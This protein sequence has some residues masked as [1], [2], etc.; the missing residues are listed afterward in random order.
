MHQNNRSSRALYGQD[1]HKQRSSNRSRSHALS[2]DRNRALQLDQRPSFT[3]KRHRH[4][5]GDYQEWEVASCVPCKTGDG[6]WSRRIGSF[7][8]VPRPIRVGKK[9]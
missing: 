3:A 5:R 1:S 8:G 9:I 7:D 2:T 4:R 6:K